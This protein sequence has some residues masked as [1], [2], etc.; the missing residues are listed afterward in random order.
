MFLKIR[1][2]LFTLLFIERQIKAL[3]MFCP[4]TWCMKKPFGYRVAHNGYLLTSCP[5]LIFVFLNAVFKKGNF[6]DLKIH[7][8]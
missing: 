7:K 1:F 6:M 3:K 5:G 4:K 8:L 2:Y